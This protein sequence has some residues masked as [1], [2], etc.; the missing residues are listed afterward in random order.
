M[1]HGNALMVRSPAF[2]R[3]VRMLLFALLA[4]FSGVTHAA[5]KLSPILVQ[6]VLDILTESESD[7]EEALT[8]LGQLVERTRSD[9]ERAFVLTERAALLI[10][11]DRMDVARAEM[12][13]LLA[14]QPP[15]FAPRLRNLYATTLL[16]QE[17]YAA[18]LEQLE[19]WSV[20]SE[21]VHPHGLFLMGYACI[22]LERFEQAVTVLER[23]VRS[24]YPTRDQWVELL[25]FAYTQVGRPE[26]AVALLESLIAEHPERQRWWKQ[27]GGIL[28]LLEQMPEGTAGLAVANTVEPLSY[29][30]QRRLARLFAHLGMPADGAELLGLAIE[31]RDEAADFE[32]LML[33]GELWMLARETDRAI[34][35][36][37]EA[38]KLAE[39]GEA[40][41]MIAQLHAQREE[42]E[43]ARDALEVSVSAYGESAPA[44]A[45]YLLAVIQINLGDLETAA[46]TVNRL[47][48][49]EEY[50]ERAANLATY[51]DGVLG[52]S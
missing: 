3:H 22:R 11:Q 8:D 19:L 15:E 18:A 13:N 16:A 20:H 46:E 44:R 4:G 41:L 1:K 7:P 12:A 32:E 40:A 25:A 43:S 37:G 27:L 45:Y 28:M 42:Y 21:V 14:D 2:R 52:Q 49:D 48:A 6:Q 29:S 24:D 5:E 35:V 9:A 36:F 17:D 39:H 51:I 38:Q 31:A 23:A 26:E 50:R 34:E 10:Q 47:Q 33:L 30:D